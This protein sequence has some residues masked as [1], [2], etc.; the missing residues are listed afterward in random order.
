MELAHSLC[1]RAIA[2][3]KGA[4]AGSGPHA[5]L[6]F[7]ES[8]VL[9]DLGNGLCVAYVVD[10]GKQLT[11]L[12]NRH[13]AEAKLDEAALHQIGVDNL[14]QIADEK[15]SIRQHGPICGAFLDGNFEASLILLDDLWETSLAH[16]V[17]N[18]FVAT[19]P[20]RDILA[21][22]DS[23][24]SE[25]IAVLKQMAS[26]VSA[27]GDHLLTASLFQRKNSEWSLFRLT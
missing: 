20:A 4:T 24:S 19:L 17:R 8:P 16:L 13:L 5:S 7:L 15:L 2:Y 3:I 27:S 10:D 11:Y 22:C 1:N 6:P 18:S 25:G 12:Q 26:K 9:K 21:F 23:Q 14:A